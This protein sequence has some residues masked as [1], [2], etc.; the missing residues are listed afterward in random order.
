MGMAARRRTSLPPWLEGRPNLQPGANI[1]YEAFQELGTCRPVGMGEGQI[2]WTAIR[3]YAE[4]YGFEGE[5]F[6]IL[7]EIIRA[8]DG[9]YLEIRNKK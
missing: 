7:L 6:D 3:Q 2:P 8:M 9:E 4:A 1:Y 5:E